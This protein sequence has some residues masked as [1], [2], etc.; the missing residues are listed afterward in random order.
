[1]GL[2]GPMMLPGLFVMAVS[3]TGVQIRSGVGSA[4]AYWNAI[5]S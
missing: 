3:K 2:F 4:T 5:G 1:M